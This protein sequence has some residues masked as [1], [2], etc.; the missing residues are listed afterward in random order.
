MMGYDMAAVG[1]IAHAG[2]HGAERVGLK[3]TVEQAG[4]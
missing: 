3:S 1:G 4:A 2:I